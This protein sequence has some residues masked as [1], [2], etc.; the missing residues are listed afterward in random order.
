MVG[1]DF[2]ALQAADN[3]PANVPESIQVPAVDV[4]HVQQGLAHGAKLAEVGDGVDYASLTADD[5]GMLLRNGSDQEG[6]L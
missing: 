4:P 1:P 2:E 5:D 3:F 6:E